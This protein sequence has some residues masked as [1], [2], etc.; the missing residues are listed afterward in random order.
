MPRRARFL[1]SHAMQS[2]YKCT[3][4]G[5]ACQPWKRKMDDETPLA[6][7]MKKSQKNC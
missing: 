1:H 6:K 4:Q 3:T 2:Y 5:A 7:N